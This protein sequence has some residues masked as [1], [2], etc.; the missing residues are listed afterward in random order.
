M[1]QIKRDN[2]TQIIKEKV[3]INIYLMR[4]SLTV[5]KIVLKNNLSIKLNFKQKI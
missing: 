4:S 3:D 1:V 5:L 2:I